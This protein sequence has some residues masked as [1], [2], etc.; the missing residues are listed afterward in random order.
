V[1]VQWRG[2]VIMMACYK[3][4]VSS[5]EILLIELLLF[6][7]SFEILMLSMLL[8]LV[9]LLLFTLRE[10]REHKRATGSS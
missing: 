3:A 8:L 7:V 1:G 5:V 4:G 6:V 9:L 10:W 2:V